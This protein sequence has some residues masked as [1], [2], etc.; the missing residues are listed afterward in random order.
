MLNKDEIIEQAHELIQIIKTKFIRK[1]GLLSRNYPPTHRTLFDNFDDLV[2]F[3]LYFGE[4]DFLIE[5]VHELHKQNLNL[6]NLCQTDYGVLYSRSLD[7]FTG[8]LYA[9]W[10]NTNDDECYFLLQDSINFIKKNLINGERF[11][12]ALHT[13]DSQ[14]AVSTYYDPWSSGI[15]ETFCEMR[16]DF[17]EAFE[18]AQTILK[19]WV[20]DKYFK[21][22]GLFPYRM[23]FSKVN[24]NFDKLLSIK[25]PRSGLKEPQ[26]ILDFNFIKSSTESSKSCFSIV[27][28]S[29]T[30]LLENLKFNFSSG[31]YSQLMKSNSTCAFT[32]LEFFRATGEYF[33]LESYEKWCNNAISSFYINGNVSMEYFPTYRSNRFNSVTAAFILADVLS[34]GAYF[35]PM[36][37]KNLPVIKN[38]LDTHLNNLLPDG[39]IPYQENAKYAHIDNQIDFAIS[40]RRYADLS[41]ERDY[42][43]KSM[44]LVENTQKNHYSKNGYYTYSGSVSKNEIDPKYNALFLKGLIHLITINEPLYP[45]YHNI[46]KDR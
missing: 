39:L 8:G 20:N 22:Y 34:D 13:S 43:G 15:L 42:L 6:K 32:L 16:V 5:Q 45:K 33:W 11:S 2:P 38:I 36:C 27:K 4:Q 23:P 30:Q 14:M 3:F 1:D 26:K 46:F 41:G 10:K 21:N 40:L 31:Y 18:S 7:E 37:K 17:P 28:K 9:L 12:G 29:G 19:S 24:Q 25:L 35:A 44:E